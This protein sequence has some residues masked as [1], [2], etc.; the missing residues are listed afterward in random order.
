MRNTIWIGVLA[1][2]L[3]ACGGSKATCEK[4]MK[5]AVECQADKM[6]GLDGSAAK[7]AM[8][9]ADDMISEAC[10]DDEVRREAPKLEECTSKSDCAEVNACLEKVGGSMFGM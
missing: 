7:E 5:R 8:S 6:G 1:L 2:A 10:K 9:F 3:G 4:V